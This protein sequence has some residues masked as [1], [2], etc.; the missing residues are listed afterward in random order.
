MLLEKAAKRTK[1]TFQ[2]LRFDKDSN[3]IRQGSKKKNQ[4]N[5]FR[6]IEEF[7]FQE[8]SSSQVYSKC[9]EE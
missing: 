1:L 3:E 9:K 2:T 4:E 7:A 8:N 5:R 6:I